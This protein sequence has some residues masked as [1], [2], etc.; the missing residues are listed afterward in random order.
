M[1]KKIIIS[2]IFANNT[3][4]INYGVHKSPNIH[5]YQSGVQF[6]NFNHYGILKVK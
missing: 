3:Y 5:F 6:T 4:L 2:T 1:L